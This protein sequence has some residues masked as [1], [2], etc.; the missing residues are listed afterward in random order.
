MEKTTNQ[1]YTTTNKLQ[2][3]Q[4]LSP[5]DIF[6]RRRIELHKTIQHVTDETK[7]QS[8]YISML[9][10]NNFENFESEV[11]MNGYIKIYC[12]YLGLNVDKILALTR[13][14]AR[15]EFKKA[16]ELQKKNKLDINISPKIIVAIILSVF[17]L[18][19]VIY[20]SFQIYNFQ[21]LPNLVITEPEDNIVVN[22]D[23]IVIK[24]STEEN[25][26]IVINGN[27]IDL[28]DDKSF[29]KEIALIEG[30]NTITI[31]AIKENN[32]SKETLKVI[33]IIYE[34]KSEITEEE[35]PESPTETETVLKEHNVK[36]SVS[37]SEAW[38]QLFVDDKQEVA[39][40]VQDGF[41]EVFI[42][43]NDFYII[44]GRSSFTKVFIDDKPEPLVW[45][46]S[47]GIGRI[48]CS[49]VNKSF[50]CDN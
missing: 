34:P 18:I 11:F 23:K 4:M 29:S 33:T 47:E 28:E 39:Q 48:K 9:E 6:K 27:Y 50:S 14:T 22:L 35:N 3:E 40:T 16:P 43:K 10:N 7:I 32:T 36:I 30:K 46:I 24:G 13:R 15:N 17:I 42:V 21:Q 49:L 37:G 2:K 31:Q 19:T 41:N 20:F 26:Q 38:I 45:Q 5:G 12:R 44:S 8:K 25:V 1:K